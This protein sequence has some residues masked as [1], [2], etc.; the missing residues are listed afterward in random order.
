VKPD[1]YRYA[2]TPPPSPTKKGED[3]IIAAKSVR[4]LRGIMIK[5][6]TNQLLIA[7][8]MNRYVPVIRYPVI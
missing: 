8:E 3:Y 7:S 1:R 4:E 6:L 2:P 5:L